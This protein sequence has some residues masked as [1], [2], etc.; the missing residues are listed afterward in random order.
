MLRGHRNSGSC[1]LAGVLAFMLPPAVLTQA[2]GAGA[3]HNESVL[4]SFC[5]QNNC[6]D[7]AGPISGLIADSAGNLYGTA[8][9]G[10]G[11]CSCGVVFKIAPGG[12]E[13]VLY[14]F[15]GGNNGIDPVGSLVMDSKGNLYGAADGG[16]N[17]AGVV[18]KVG[19][20][21]GEKTLYMF[22]GGSDGAYPSGALIADKKGNLYGMTA[23]GGAYG[24]GTVF[25]LAPNGTESVLY[26][27]AGG[28]DGLAPTGGLIS[29]KAGNF[30]GATNG[31][32][33]GHNGIV[34]KL[35]PGGVET[36]LYAFGGGS[37]G[38]QPAAGVIADKAGNLDGTAEYGGTDDGGVVFKI[39]PEGTETV[40]YTFCSETDCDDG[41]NP[42]AGVIMGK[43]GDL[44]GT[45][46]LGGGNNPGG[47]GVVFKVTPEGKE[48]VL[49]AFDYQT[50][51]GVFPDSALLELK[52]DFY[53]T[54]S[55]GGPGG[56]GTVFKLKN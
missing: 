13:T 26:S 38:G 29:D 34:F 16:E 6:S 37:D 36:V 35:A 49:H 18:F 12:I 44:Y 20:N 46:S 7:G 51:D 40:L 33:S 22:S 19:G 28:T 32:G 53:G 1:V 43:N 3:K 54:T 24:Y 56:L 41:D 4:Y 2:H 23:A 52:N 45:T 50:G 47:D 25:E 30:Y 27:F 55:N 17:N 48:A 8:N 15:V 31:G 21:G 39:T 42:T 11:N 14:T 9:S 10:G 5:T